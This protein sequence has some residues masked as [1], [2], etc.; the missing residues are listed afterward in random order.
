[1]TTRARTGVSGRGTPRVPIGGGGG[2]N[3]VTGATGPQGATGA[4]GATGP[5]GNSITGAT[6]ATGATST[7]PGPTGATGP[8][9]LSI[10]G[11]T[12]ATGAMGPTGATGPQGPQGNGGLVGATGATGSTGATGAQGDS[13]TG[14]TGATGSTGATGAQGITGPVGNAGGDLNGTY[15]SPSVVAITE[16]SVPSRLAIGDIP[17]GAALIRIGIGVVGLVAGVVG[18]AMIWDGTKWASGTNFGA[19]NLTTTGAYISNSAAPVLRLGRAPGSGVG[20]ASSVGDIRLRNN[21][22]GTGTGPAIY[23]RRGDDAADVFLIGYESLLTNGS[24][25]IGNPS[26]PLLALITMTASTINVSASGTVTLGTSGSLGVR[27]G[28][29][30]FNF[31]DTSPSP[32]MGQL[33]R[34]ATNA[35]GETMQITAQ[36]VSGNGI[37]TGGRLNIAGGAATGT[38]G[39]HMGGLLDLGGGPAT[40]GTGGNI[41]LHPGTGIAQGFGTLTTA[42]GIVRLRWDSTGMGFYTA[43]PVPQPARVGQYVNSTGGTVSGTRTLVP[44]SS[45]AAIDNNFATIASVQNALELAVHNIG[46][47]A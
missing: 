42:S 8:Q 23:G 21:T 29:N 14:A 31:D 9:G 39:T 15:P 16:T 30:N 12:G 17:D 3:G 36:A 47:T 1:M 28:G 33:V 27:I 13:I 7:V 37:T 44:S 4:T 46:I 10:T 24:L 20:S 40:S 26:A 25:Q 6:G 2:G 19:Q 32:V 38:G 22:G 41:N 45:Q 35:T 18:A 43:T 5:Q 34:L 11:A